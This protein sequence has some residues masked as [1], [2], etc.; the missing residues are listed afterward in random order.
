VASLLSDL[1]ANG[2]SRFALPDGCSIECIA[3]RRHVNNF[4]ADNV[5]STKLAVDG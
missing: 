3:M 4:Y 2:S 1:E 5:T